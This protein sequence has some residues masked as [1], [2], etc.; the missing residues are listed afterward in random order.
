APVFQ[1]FTPDLDAVITANVSDDVA[2]EHQK[3]LIKPDLSLYCKGIS[4]PR[5]TVLP[6]ILAFFEF[7]P[8]ASSSG[9]RDNGVP[10]VFEKDTNLARETRGQLATYAGAMMAVQFRTHVFAVE[11]TGENARLLRFDREGCIVTESFSY[12]TETHL[13]EFLWRFNHASSEDR[14][15]D[16][17]VTTPPASEDSHVSR[18]RTV[19]RME[20][21]ANVWRFEVLDEA[22]KIAIMAV[23]GTTPNP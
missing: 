9:F 20:P 2:W 22:P 5:T 6:D 18:A 17:S 8:K 15:Y 12:V 14:G 4:R 7:K 10:G 11:V 1:R 16:K 13:V 23:S 21:T 3:H 19:L